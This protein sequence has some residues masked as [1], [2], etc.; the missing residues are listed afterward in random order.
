MSRYVALLRGINVGGRNRVAMADLRQL[1]E[2]LGHTEVATYIPSGNA[3]FSSPDTEDRVLL[4]R[5]SPAAGAPRLG[6]G[7]GRELPAGRPPTCRQVPQVIAPNSCPSASC[8]YRLARTFT[9]SSSGS[10][11]RRPR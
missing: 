10:S 1:T 4:G 9:K 2:A 5:G 6:N 8:T 7:R 3:V 11:L